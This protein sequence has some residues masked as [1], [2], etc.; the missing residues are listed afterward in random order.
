MFLDT[1]DVVELGLNSPEKFM[2][3]TPEQKAEIIGRS[4][5]IYIH[6][7]MYPSHFLP[8][9]IDFLNL[10]GAKHRYD[11]SYYLSAYFV[12]FYINEIIAK[13]ADLR[14]LDDFRSIGIAT[15][16]NDD[17]EYCYLIVPNFIDD[18]NMGAPYFNI[19]TYDGNLRFKNVNTSDDDYDE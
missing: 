8:I 19:Y 16:L 2:D 14:D 1:Y 13:G 10:E 4:Q 9:A 5:I 7:D 11:D 6:W 12:A 17:I 15:D 18:I 3:L